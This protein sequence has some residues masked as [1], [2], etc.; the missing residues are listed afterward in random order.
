[1]ST[2]NHAAP[3]NEPIFKQFLDR[4]LYVY[5]IEYVVKRVQRDS[6]PEA[7]PEPIAESNG[8]GRRCFRYC[9]E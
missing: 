3:G 2:E 6:K 7:I 1:M 8:D 4:V 5:F 9:C